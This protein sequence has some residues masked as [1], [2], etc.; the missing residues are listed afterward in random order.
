MPVLRPC[1]SRFCE[2][3]TAHV[4]QKS[5]PDRYRGVYTDGQLQPGWDRRT[6]RTIKPFYDYSSSI[7][8]LNLSKVSKGLAI[9]EK[10]EVSDA[11]K[12]QRLFEYFDEDEDGFL[13]FEEARCLY[14]CSQSAE[15]S[16][17]M[18]DGVLASFR[19]ESGLDVQALT[20]LYQKLGTLD[21]DFDKIDEWEEVDDEEDDDFIIKDC[22]D[23]DEFERIM[24]EHGLQPCSITATG[25]LRLPDGCVA[26]HRQFHYIYKQRG[27]RWTAEE[28][29]Y[30]KSASNNSALLALG[31]SYSVPP[32]LQIA[33]SPSQGTV[34]K[35][36]V[37]AV[38]R[39]NAKARMH[40]GV[41]QNVMQTRFTPRIRS[42]RGD[43]AGGR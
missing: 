22:G 20:S 10:E 13:N 23:E 4:R 11:D 28:R 25:D 43:A 16:K 42:V 29:Q 2:L 36:Q 30:K 41:K 39:R 37:I 5:H 27:R 14:E 1:V 34:Q 6:P 8:E 15:L 26:A 18:Y 9:K 32:G 7:N 40:L 3:L 17:E 35:K 12:I 19:L 31:N 33:L 21:A 24:K 38:F